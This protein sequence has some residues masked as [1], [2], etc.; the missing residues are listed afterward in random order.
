MH[1]LSGICDLSSAE[2]VNKIVAGLTLTNQMILKVTRQPPH[3][4]PDSTI[5]DISYISGYKGKI[6]QNNNNFRY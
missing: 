5:G 3:N 2:A 4:C 6:M 1:A